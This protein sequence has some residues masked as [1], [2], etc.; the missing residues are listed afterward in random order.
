MIREES[1]LYRFV[2]VCAIARPVGIN[3]SPAISAVRRNRFWMWF[4]MVWFFG[5]WVKR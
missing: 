1:K 3:P 2:K 5:Y 4:F